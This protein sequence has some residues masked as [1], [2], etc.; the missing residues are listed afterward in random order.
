MD[1]EFSWSLDGLSFYLCFIFVP[2]IFLDI[3]NSES[4]ILQVGG[5][6]HL[7]TVGLSIYWSWSYQVLSPLLGILAKVIPH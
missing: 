4:K 7:S 2:A 5:W 1:P 6:S 3:N